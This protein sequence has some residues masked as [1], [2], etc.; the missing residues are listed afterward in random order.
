L[1]ITTT[2]HTT[3]TTGAPHRT[4]PTTPSLTVGTQANSGKLRKHFGI[5]D[6]LPILNIFTTNKKKYTTTNQ[7]TNQPTTQKGIQNEH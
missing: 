4:P 3:G 7:P 6:I 5:F 1:W 2:S